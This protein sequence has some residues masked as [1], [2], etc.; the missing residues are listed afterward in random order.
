MTRAAA[1]G[2][3]VV[4]LLLGLALGTSL[5][6][7]GLGGPLVALWSGAPLV[8]PFAIRAR[9]RGSMRAPGLVA[10]VMGVEATS[11]VSSTAIGY[12]LFVAPV[13]LLCFMTASAIEPPSR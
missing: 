6:S 13:L 4:A 1:W 9:E 2:S 8:V 3:A 11:I 10:L 7:Q 5:A 12:A